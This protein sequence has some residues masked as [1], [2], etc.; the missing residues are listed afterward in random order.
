MASC[1]GLEAKLLGL[2]RLGALTP[3]DLTDTCI[4]VVERFTDEPKTAPWEQPRVD[5]TGKTLGELAR[6]H[7]VEAKDR[8]LTGT[9]SV[10][11]KPK[12]V[13]S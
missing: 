8:F 4:A 10:D 2:L 9:S 13:Q 6:E 3:G 5:G 7:I 11:E 12:G 1:K